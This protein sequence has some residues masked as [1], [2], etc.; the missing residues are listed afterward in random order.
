MARE[1]DKE[2][3]KFQRRALRVVSRGGEM[4]VVWAAGGREWRVQHVR[5][6]Q[7]CGACLAL[8]SQPLRARHV[9]TAGAAERWETNEGPSYRDDISCF[10]VYFAEP[11]SGAGSGTT[12]IVRTD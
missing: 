9:L 7:L 12:T 11:G 3:E 5:R 8:I 2:K 10:V 4:G 1:T 6:A